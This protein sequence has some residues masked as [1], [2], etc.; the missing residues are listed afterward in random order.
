MLLLAALALPPL[1]A[2]AV[3]DVRRRLIPDAAVAALAIIGV[4]AAAGGQ[5]L[6]AAL[7]CGALCA[8]VG[9]LLAAAR[10]WGWGDAKLLG[11]AGL[12]A[13]PAG[14]PLLAGATALIGGALAALLLLIRSGLRHS[15]WRLPANAPRWLRAEQRRLLRAPSV[16][17]GLAIAAGLV[18]A[19]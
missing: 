13:G 16:P 7:S 6:S 5:A 9:S 10:L 11:A 8:G 18:A 2:V 12:V 15:G 14:L 3:S 1:A 19:M 17:Y 4:G